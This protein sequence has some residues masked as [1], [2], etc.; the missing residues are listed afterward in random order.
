[1]RFAR[2]GARVVVAARSET[3][4]H[5]LAEGL[6]QQG[7]EATVATAE[8]TDP[9]QVRAVADQAVAA[10]GRLDTWVHAAGVGLWASFA[11]MT[12]EEWRRVVEVNLNG[13]VYGA[14]AALPHLRREGRGA[15]IHVSSA[16]A[17][18]ALPLQTAYAASKHGLSGFL[19]ALR[20]ELEHEGVAIQVTEVMPSAI[21]T[22]LFDKARSHI[23]TKPVPMRAFYQPSVAAEAILYAAAHPIDEIV[24]GGAGRAGML[25]QQAAPSLMN[26]FLRTL[27][28]PLQ[29][30]KEP[31][32]P[33]APD[34]LF[35]HLDG[36]DR[37]QGD[38]TRESRA[39]SLYTWLS[40]HPRVRRV[41]AL[42]ALGAAAALAGRGRRA[43]GEHR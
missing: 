13:A 37:S 2:R 7:G 15:L 31:K 16:E 21:N 19:K 32:G 20:L 17:R 29:R 30:T 3:A 36:Y 11:Q 22:P 28:F 9:E 1:M 38:F 12:P 10:H 6:R 42:A 5:A 4:L 18:L 25:L 43:R 8:V 23:G 35:R 33:D 26:G 27:A 34:N 24:A 14:M 39:T 40:M 41:L